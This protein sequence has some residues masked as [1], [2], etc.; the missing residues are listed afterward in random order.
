[1]KFEC[2]VGKMR[3]TLSVAER[4]LTRRISEDDLP[5]LASH[6]PLFYILPE[7]KSAMMFN[8]VS[9]K[10]QISKS[11]LS[12]I[13]NKYQALGILSKLECPQD[14]RSIYIALTEAG[15]EIRVCLKKYEGEFLDLMLSGL[16]EASKAEFEKNLD[17]VVRNATK[18]QKK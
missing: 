1:M 4:Y 13:I 9:K 17:H 14:K 15:L 8:E 7:D 5:I 12:D 16:S 6:I 10:W 11:S 3:Y 18:Y 2:A